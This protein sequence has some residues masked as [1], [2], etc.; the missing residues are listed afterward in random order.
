MLGRV[1]R[2]EEPRHLLQAVEVIR[3]RQVPDRFGRERRRGQDELDELDA[4]L[5]AHRPALVRHDL[6]GHL[7]LTER[8]LEA[9]AP[10]DATR[11]D[12][13]RHRLLL[14]LGVPVARERLDDRVER[15]QV[16]L[17]H[18]VRLAAVQIDRAFVDR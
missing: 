10:L 4:F 14:R 2:P 8:Q 1:Q 5:A 16:E 18:E 6:L 12:D 15:R 9:E 13:R 3:L 17:T 7:D 11:L